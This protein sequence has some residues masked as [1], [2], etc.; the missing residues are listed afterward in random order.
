MTVFHG[1]SPLLNERISQQDNLST[2]QCQRD[3]TDVMDSAIGLDSGK[4]KPDTNMSE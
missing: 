1:F 3:I 4:K 2:R